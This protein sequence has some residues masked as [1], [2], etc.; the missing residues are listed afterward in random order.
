MPVRALGLGGQGPLIGPYTCIRVTLLFLTTVRDLGEDAAEANRTWRTVGRVL[1]ALRLSARFARAVVCTLD[2]GCN[3]NNNNNN[4]TSFE[5]TDDGVARR[6]PCPR[7][8]NM[9]LGKPHAAPRESL[10]EMASVYFR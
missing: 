4:T 8:E 5:P 9:V 3:N 10:G 1:S 7:P 2:G 6:H